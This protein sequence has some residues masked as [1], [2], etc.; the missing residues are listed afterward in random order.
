MALRPS[1]KST[2]TVPT[3]NLNNQTNN[4]DIALELV[5]SY[6]SSGAYCSNHLT[7]AEENGYT[8][9]HSAARMDGYY[10]ASLYVFMKEWLD[11]LNVK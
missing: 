8:E 11:K 4:H 6:L 5:K 9:L 7:K 2:I 1:S 10:M 3:A